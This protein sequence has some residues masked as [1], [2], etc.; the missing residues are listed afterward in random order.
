MSLV[1]QLGDIKEALFLA[2]QSLK[3]FE[4]P[5][6]QI[7]RKYHKEDG[8]LSKQSL[9]SVNSLVL[10]YV[11]IASIMTK[12]KERAVASNVL[13]SALALSRRFLAGTPIETKLSHIHEQDKSGKTFDLSSHKPFQPV[14]SLVLPVAQNFSLRRLQSGGGHGNDSRQGFDGYFDSESN[15]DHQR[16]FNNGFSHD[17]SN[18]ST[19]YSSEMAFMSTNFRPGGNFAMTYAGPGAGAGGYR[20]LDPFGSMSSSNS[21]HNNYRDKRGPRPYVTTEDDRYSKHRSFQSSPMNHDR[22]LSP[23][24]R[25]LFHGGIPHQFKSPSRT[26]IAEDQFGSS[27]S[28]RGSE[29]SPGSLEN[30]EGYDDHHH[31]QSQQHVLSKRSRKVSRLR[32][33]VE[34]INEA[35]KERLKDQEERLKLERDSIKLQKLEMEERIKRAQTEFK[36]QTQMLER[37]TEQ[38]RAELEMIRSTSSGPTHVHNTNGG[39]GNSIGDTNNAVSRAGVIRLSPN[40]GHDNGED[41]GA[42]GGN[43]PAG[44]H[45]PSFRNTN[46]LGH[47]QNRHKP[48]ANHSHNSTVNSQVLSNTETNGTF[49]GIQSYEEGIVTGVTQNRLVLDPGS[50][51]GEDGQITFK[52]NDSPTKF[53]FNSSLTAENDHRHHHAASAGSLLV[54]DDSRE[55]TIESSMESEGFGKLARQAKRTGSDKPLKRG[56]S[57]GGRHAFKGRPVP[58]G[59]SG[60]GGEKGKLSHASS[61]DSVKGTGPA[62]P[63]DMT[64]PAL[65]ERL[66]GVKDSKQGVLLD[67]KYQKVGSGR[68]NSGQSDTTEMVRQLLMEEATADGRAKSAGSAKPHIHL[69]KQTSPRNLHSGE[70]IIATFGGIHGDGTESGE[71]SSERQKGTQ[72]MHLGTGKAG[73]GVTPSISDLPDLTLTDESGDGHKSGSSSNTGVRPRYK[74]ASISENVGTQSQGEESALSSPNFSKNHVSGIS[75]PNVSKRKNDLEDEEDTSMALSED[76][77]S[78]A[79]IKKAET[80]EGLNTENDA[81]SRSDSKGRSGGAPSITVINDKNGVNL[82]E[83]YNDPDNRRSSLK[84]HA[85]D[86]IDLRDANNNNEDETTTTTTAVAKEDTT[87]NPN[88]KTDQHSP[89]LEDKSPTNSSDRPLKSKD[90]ITDSPETKSKHTTPTIPTTTTTANSNAEATTAVNNEMVAPT[91]IVNANSSYDSEN[92]L[93]NAYEGLLDQ[94]RLPRQGFINLE[95]RNLVELIQYGLDVKGETTVSQVIHGDGETYLVS[96]HLVLLNHSN[97]VDDVQNSSKAGSS[98][99]QNMSPNFKIVVS[100]TIFNGP[101]GVKISP[102]VLTKHELQMMFKENALVDGIEEILPVDKPIHFLYDYGDL[103]RYCILPFIQIPPPE[104][105]KQRKFEIWIKAPGIMDDDIHINFLNEECNFAV[106]VIEDRLLRITLTKTADQMKKAITL[107]LSLDDS[108]AERFITEIT[109]KGPEG[110]KMLPSHELVRSQFYDVVEPIICEMNSYLEANGTTSYDNFGRENYIYFKGEASDSFKKRRFWAVRDVTEDKT[111]GKQGWEV[112]VKNLYPTITFN[113]EWEEVSARYSYDSDQLWKDFGVQSEY[114]DSVNMTVIG[115]LLLKTMKFNTIEQ[116]PSGKDLNRSYYRQNL[117]Q[118]LSREKIE[119]LISSRKLTGVKYKSPLTMS[120]L[121]C[122]GSLLGIKVTSYNPELC[123]ELGIFLTVNEEYWQK[124]ETVS[125]EES[126]EHSHLSFLKDNQILNNTQLGEFLYQ[127]GFKA[128]ENKLD[129]ERFN[130]MLYLSISTPLGRTVLYSFENLVEGKKLSDSRL[131][132]TTE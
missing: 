94:K 97:S 50:N 70:H 15:S 96:C 26:G 93:I 29:D 105:G 115:S 114:L 18:M 31:H 3:E 76:I 122:K 8:E 40:S 101:A 61:K 51:Q 92:S 37:Q 20:N 131:F 88:T 63:N 24:N 130:R 78:H 64:S 21:S 120:L 79:H 80:T 129:G 116:L 5:I 127:T 98:T 90:T 38:L 117:E 91:N 132:F 107:D 99:S 109:A 48:S 83:I 35:E 49:E 30:F 44:D 32:R 46:P 10:L 1:L 22:F 53:H 67:K 17:N 9:Q 126:Q 125:L 118:P 13:L 33:R 2:V 45:T 121:A 119:T 108:C 100:A 95:S 19:Q 39:Q 66:Q 23:Q 113:E 102:I 16:F 25:E 104:D 55:K 82:S 6:L 124:G 71:V 42:R 86:G 112:Y 34:E 75:E 54:I 87:G 65:I 28:L 4:H 12:A 89:S 69:G 11:N 103:L 58:K 62:N 43:L 111:N 84:L 27:G 123:E 110:S 7:T 57:T 77:H 106:Y 36:N 14:F 47:V 52:N 85:S 41:H 73:F 81:Y 68:R 56:G 128:I 60:N 72:S 59:S 74:T